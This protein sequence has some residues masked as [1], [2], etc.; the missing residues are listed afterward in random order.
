MERKNIVSLM[1]IVA[2]VAA[3]IFAGCVEEGTSVSTPSP[4]VATAT[5]TPDSITFVGSGDKVER[6]FSVE[7]GIAMF[8]MTH[9]GDMFIVDLLD[10]RRNRI[11]NL[12]LGLGGPFNG[13]KIVGVIKERYYYLDI[14]A[15]GNWR[16]TIKRL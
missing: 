10:D 6:F 4:E 15:D 12:A 14:V 7:N 16:I 5:S 11:D 13:S 2:F 8:K 1:A 9:D 3:V